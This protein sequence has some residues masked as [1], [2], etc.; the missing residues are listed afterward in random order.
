M[1]GTVKSLA[2]LALAGSFAAGVAGKGYTCQHPPYE[3]EILSTSPL[4]IYLTNFIT[5]EEQAHL[6]N[7]T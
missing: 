7:A 1:R 2:Q 4:V 3:M 6:L 5:P